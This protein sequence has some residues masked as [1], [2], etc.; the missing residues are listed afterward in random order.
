ML[1][2]LLVFLFIIIMDMVSFVNIFLYLVMEEDRFCFCFN[3]FVIFF[4]I[5]WKCLC[6]VFLFRFLMV[7]IMG[8]LVFSNEYIWWEKMIILFSF[9]FCWNKCVILK[10]FFLFFVLCFF[11]LI[12]VRGIMFCD[13][14]VCVVV[15]VDVVLIIFFWGLF[16]VDL[17]VYLNCGISDLLF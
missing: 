12:M 7:W 15:C 5:F 13:S 6:D 9:I 1:F 16:C 8:I 17:F 3:W 10:L 11:D 2:N 14:K 4:K